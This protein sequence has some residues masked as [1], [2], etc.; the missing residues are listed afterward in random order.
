MFW[1]NQAQNLYKSQ[2]TQTIPS[3]G[4]SWNL[5]DEYEINVLVAPK[6]NSWWVFV[7]FA[8]T[9]KRDLIYFHSRTGNVLKYYRKNR[10]LLWLW[11]ST[12]THDSWAYIQMHDVSE[13]INYLSNNTS[14]FGFA[15][16]PYE[17]PLTIKMYGGRINYWG[18]AITVADANILLPVSSTKEIIFD[19]ADNTFKAIDTASLSSYACYHCGTAITW[20]SS[21]TSYTEARQ[22][23]LWTSYS[24]TFFQVVSWILSLKDWSIPSTKLDASVQT[25]L[26]QAHS[27]TNK[28]TVLD[29]LTTS[30]WVLYFNGVQIALNNQA[31]PIISVSSNFIGPVYASLADLNLAYPSPAFW[32]QWFWCIAEWLYYDAVW[33]VWTARSNGW[34]SPNAALWVAGKTELPTPT[35]ILNGT[36]TSGTG[37]P[38]CVQPG[39]LK[40]VKDSLTSLI[41]AVS[42]DSFKNIGFYA[43]Q[44]IA[45]NDATFLEY[46]TTF[47]LATN[48]LNISRVAWDT[49]ISIPIFGSWVAFTTFKAA[50][51]KV[52]TP[53]QNLNF[54]IES[55]NAWNPSWTP[56]TNGTSTIAQASLTTSFADTTLTLAWSVTLTIGV[57]YWLVIFQGTYWSETVSNTNYYDIWFTAID[58]TPRW[59]LA[60]SWSAWSNPYWLAVTDDDNIT[61]SLTSTTTT[62]RWYRVQALQDIVITTINKS[63]TCTA[64]RAVIR[65]DA[66]TILQTANFSGNVAT[67]TTPELISSGSFFRVEAD[68]NG[69]S[70]T[71]HQNNAASFPQARTNV[72]YNTWSISWANDWSAWNIDS[73]ITKEQAQ[74]KFVYL[75]STGLLDVVVAL[76][77]AAHSYK[78]NVFW[79][80]RISSAVWTLTEIITD[81]FKA[82]FSSL[83]WKLTEYFLWNA[84]WSISTTPWTNKYRISRS[85]SDTIQYIDKKNLWSFTITAPWSTVATQNTYW[86]P[87]KVNITNGTVTVV[88]TSRDN[89]TYYQEY[90]ATGCSVILQPWDYLK[91]TYSVAPTLT[92]FYI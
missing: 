90:A 55:D 64:T 88:S 42:S 71:Y 1:R 54:R 31:I 35:H 70:Y 61:L 44:S 58:T 87:I 13:W 33:W 30:S 26:W 57:R 74:K 27:H 67:L 8:N 51:R 28:T 5:N 34:T 78:V 39:H 79:Y 24:S 84:A 9:T 17:T 21:I 11:A 36:N 66:G 15:E 77:S 18:P 40:D 80:S 50:L 19:F 69:A 7:D 46:M 43:W 38:L 89:V 3:I 72:T 12:Q 85:V 14:D 53:T 73:I 92:A 41:N 23:F 45:V 82:W 10:D 49:R 86:Q 60:R 29:L 83:L 20:P 63:A 16:W 32:Q 75:S 68:S 81:W 62:S 65:N 59:V 2:I 25:A 48:A 6:Y 37:N 47:S 4:S 52:G 91:M 56:V 22:F 76:T